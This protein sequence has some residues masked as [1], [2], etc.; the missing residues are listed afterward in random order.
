MFFL[1]FVI[2][3][4]VAFYA[5]FTHQTF[6]LMSRHY[7]SHNTLRSGARLRCVRRKERTVYDI[8]IKACF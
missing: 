6:G 7:C 1:N 2:E 3:F 5:K 8:V 4:K